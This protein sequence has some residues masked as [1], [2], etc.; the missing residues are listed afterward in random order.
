MSTDK[1]IPK[2]VLDVWTGAVPIELRLQDGDV[3]CVTPPDAVCLL[4]SRM[5]YLPSI[6]RPVIEYFQNMAVECTTE[7]WF[8]VG[9]IVLKRFVQ[10]PSLCYPIHSDSHFLYIAI[11]RS[12]FCT[13]F[14]DIINLGDRRIPGKSPFISNHPQQASTWTPQAANTARN[15]TSTASNKHYNCFTGQQDSSWNLVSSN[16]PICSRL[17]PLRNGTLSSR[18]VTSCCHPIPPR[19]SIFPCGLSIAWVS[20]GSDW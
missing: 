19:S 3:A 7:A 20:F 10:F 13:I 2:L 1:S 12:E 17:L 15:S 4:A 11:F 16:R 9:G 18:F 6:A 14:M 8:E 5:G